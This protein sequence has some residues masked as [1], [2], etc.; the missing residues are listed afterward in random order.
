MNTPKIAFFG[1]P[2]IAV[3]VLQILESHGMIPAVVVTNPDRPAGR[4]MELAPTPVK[5]WAQERGVEVYQP[6]TLRD[7]NAIPNLAAAQW[8]LFVVFAYGLIMPKW[9]IELPKYG[10]IN[11]HPS[12]LPKLR[13]ASPIRTSIL[14]GMKDAGVSIM[15][16]DEKMDHGPILAQQRVE[17]GLFIPGSELDQRLAREGGELLYDVILRLLNGT[18]TPREQDHAQ[19]TYTKKITKAMGELVIDP[20]HLPC[21]HEAEQMLRK[22][23][24]FD[25]WPGT[26]FFYNGKRIKIMRA[27][28]KN[29]C[30]S[31][32]S[33]TP[34]GK[35]EMDF[36]VFL[37]SLS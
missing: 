21:G 11:L 13:G 25:I 12:V 28:I 5:V 37:Q 2:S 4:G 9:L 23:Y 7:P 17:E 22:I 16:M 1:T 15:F 30:L 26:Y 10:T 36:S 33:V 14:E 27:H 19:A 20:L 29:G 6:E 34:E 31:L 24:A 8:D 35:K 3:E 18:I 32:D